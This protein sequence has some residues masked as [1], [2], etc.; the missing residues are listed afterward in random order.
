MLNSLQQKPDYTIHRRAAGDDGA[1]TP[2]EEQQAGVINCHGFETVHGT[3]QFTGG[4][5][6]SVKLTPFELIEYKTPAGVATK[7]WVARGSKTS[8]LVEGAS[9]EFNTHGGGRWFLIISDTTGS[10][11]RIE[12]LLAGGT[13]A[14]EGSI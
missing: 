11:E 1:A 14:V 10:P 2:T 13:R 5:G 8:A 9:F 12:V 3:V 4:S 6:A 7:A